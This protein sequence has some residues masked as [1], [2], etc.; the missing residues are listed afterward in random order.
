MELRETQ[1]QNHQV[2][3]PFSLVFSCYVELQKAAR[4][5]PEELNLRGSAKVE[6][7]FGLFTF[8]CNHVELQIFFFKM[9]SMHVDTVLQD[10]TV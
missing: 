4:C 6:F 3:K 1:W 10:P 9:L 8:C 2:A 5:P 7:L